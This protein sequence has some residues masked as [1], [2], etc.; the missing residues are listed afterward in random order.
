MIWRAKG[1]MV[2]TTKARRTLWVDEYQVFKVGK[3]V[4][5]DNSRV[6]DSEPDE[7]GVPIPLPPT[8]RLDVVFALENNASLLL[9]YVR[10]R[11]RTGVVK[12]FGSVH[13]CMV[14][15]DPN[16]VRRTRYFSWP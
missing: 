5:L 11:P 7:N 4:I 15:G 6:L 8:A 2:F 1:E 12:V 3:P 13:K 10:D 9:D 16:G 14:D